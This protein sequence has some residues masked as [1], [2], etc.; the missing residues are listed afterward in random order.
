MSM[1]RQQST[2]RDVAVRVEAFSWL[3][4]QTTALGDVL[5]ID[6]L[7]KGFQYEGERVPLMGPQGIFKPKVL[8]EIPLSITT[9][10]DG[11]YDDSF[12]DQG[13]LR[14][15][16]R[17]TDPYHHENVGLRKAMQTQTPLVYFHGVVKGKYLATWPIFIVGDSPGELAFTVAADDTGAA[18]TAARGSV[19]V[20]QSILEASGRRAYITATM[21]VRLHQRG[22]RE[23]VLRAYQDQCAL[24]RLRHRNLLDAAH[25]V[26]DRDPAGDPL[27]SNGLSLCKIHHAAF[28][29]LLL[30][31]RPD[32][33]VE[34]HPKVLRETDGPMLR[35]GLQGLHKASLV[36]PRTRRDY[37]DPERLKDRYALFSGAA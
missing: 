24:C 12:D 5:P 32:Y 25:I 7:R 4:D 29:H 9:A 33:V 8:P 18:E 36:L 2:E 34:I 3:R 19:A 35:H 17:G 30:G 14:Y 31:I 22:F 20:P 23:R 27:V 15:R 1:I 37:P 11:P 10:P 6:L 16:Y 28:D 13:W 21:R 26:P